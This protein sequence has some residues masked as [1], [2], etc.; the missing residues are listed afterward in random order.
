MEGALV[1]KGI[2]LTVMLVMLYTIVVDSSGEESLGP[3][4]R[5]A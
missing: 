2:G 3:G 1:L 4:L 5:T